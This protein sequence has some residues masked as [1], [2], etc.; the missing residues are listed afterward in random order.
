MVNAGVAFR[1]C[2][3][4]LVRVPR[5]RLAGTA[6]WRG[7]TR[8]KVAATLF[9]LMVVL[10]ADATP[11]GLLP[12]LRN[13]VFD[14]YQ[15]DWPSPRSAQPI[16]VIDIDSQSV[17]ILYFRSGS[18]EVDAKS[19]GDLL[20]AAATPKKM[21]DIDVSV[22]GHADATGSGA[23]NEALSLKRADTVRD[24]LVAGG[25]PGGVINI[26]YW[27]KPLRGSERHRR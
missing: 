9:A 1:A 2:E 10:I 17:Y 8:A 23:Y 20:A 21:S 13:A 18:T 4:Q 26:A 15:Q 12:T 6:L 22:V 5:P 16:L 25:I 14:T 7:A 24:A 11:S 19:R 27:T 3:R